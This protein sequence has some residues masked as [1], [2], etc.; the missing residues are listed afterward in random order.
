MTNCSHIKPGIRTCFRQARAT[1]APFSRM[2][3][4][5][6]C[7]PAHLVDSRSGEEAV[8]TLTGKGYGPTSSS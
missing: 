5:T 2:N 6:Q 3:A 4:S 8:N 7:V 1:H